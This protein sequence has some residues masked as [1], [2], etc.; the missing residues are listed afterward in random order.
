MLLDDTV[1]LEDDEVVVVVVV[2]V[3]VL[4]SGFVTV[5]VDELV[6]DELLDELFI[7]LLDALLI[8]LFIELELELFIISIDNMFITEANCCT[9]I[10]QSFFI[11]FMSQDGGGVGLQSSETDDFQSLAAAE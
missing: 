3:V 1:L 11:W 10:G 8:E 5:L 9:S 6:D 2:V 7:E 4:P